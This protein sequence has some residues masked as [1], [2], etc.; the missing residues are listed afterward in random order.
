MFNYGQIRKLGLIWDR[1]FI[2]TDQRYYVSTCVPT[3]FGHF[4]E[5]HF[6]FS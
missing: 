4:E 6:I 5:I 1:K 2:E 3:H